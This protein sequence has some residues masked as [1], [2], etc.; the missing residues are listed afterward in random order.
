MKKSLGAAIHAMPAPVW[1]VGSYGKNGEPNIMTAAWGGVCCSSP[2]CVAVSLRK[3]RL[4]YDNI[5]ENKSF[6]I[7]I[8]SK[9]YA[10]EADYVGNV[11]GKNSDKFT[12][13][14]L[15]PVK[16][17]IVNAPY[18][19]EFPL[20]IECTLLQVVDI[21]VHTQFIGE[22]VDVKVDEEVLGEKGVIEIDR[23]NPIIL[24]ASSGKY[25][26][27]GEYLGQAHDLGMKL[28]K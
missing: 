12:V 14:G 27:H 22:I 15:T 6:T 8:P 3:S 9:Q 4:T 18:V 7:N 20:V 23:V 21:G 5:L 16:G 2:P 1:V 26:T 19:K 28:K 13:T 10:V 11:S 17:D 25:Y 24:N